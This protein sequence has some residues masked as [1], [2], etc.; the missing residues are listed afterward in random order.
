MWAKRVVLMCVRV[1]WQVTALF[2]KE[3]GGQKRCLT[4]ARARRV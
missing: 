4:G 1:P 2:G 3:A